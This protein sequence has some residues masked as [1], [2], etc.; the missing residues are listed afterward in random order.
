VNR[1]EM[2][3]W[4]TM[5]SSRRLGE[6]AREAIMDLIRSESIAPGPVE[7]DFSGVETVSW[8]FADECFGVMDELIGSEAMGTRLRFVNMDQ[9]TVAPVIRAVVR[10]RRRKL[11]GRVSVSA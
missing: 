4:G 8:S 5:P 3:Q 7:I 1:F 6:A 9:Q 11:P 10:Q 2:I